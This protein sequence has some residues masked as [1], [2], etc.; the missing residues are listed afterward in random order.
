VKPK[1]GE[2]VYVPSETFLYRMDENAMAYD[3]HKLDAPSNL[4]L[5]DPSEDE[6][7]SEHYYKIFFREDDEWYV[8]K[9]DIYEV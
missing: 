4:L 7:L 1:T 6:F 3:F 2:L 8:K 5:V 9:Q